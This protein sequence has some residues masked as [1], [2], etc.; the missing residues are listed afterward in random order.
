VLQL[1]DGCIGHQHLSGLV[2]EISKKVICGQ[3]RVITGITA[4]QIFNPL[5]EKG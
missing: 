4:P 3:S 2:D 1:N 5:N